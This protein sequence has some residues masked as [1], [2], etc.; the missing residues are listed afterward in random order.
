MGRLFKALR[1]AASLG[2]LAPGAL[3]HALTGST[4]DL[5]YQGM[6]RL[7]CLTGGASNDF[8]HG[9]LRRFRGC[10][11]LAPTDGVL[12]TFDTPGLA[13]VTEQ[14]REQGYYVFPKLLSDAVV[15]ELL[16]YALSAEGYYVPGT[17]RKDEAEA[18]RR[19][20][21]F[22]RNRPL[23]VRFD[24]PAATL[25]KEPA[26]QRLLTDRSILAVA[27]S[28]LGCDPILDL[29]T[30]WWHTAASPEPS[31]EA[32]QLFHFDMDRI[33]WLKF[34]VYLTDVDDRSG[35]HV[36]VPGSH[37]RSGIPWRMLQKGY[38]RLSDDEVQAYYGPD[39]LRRFTGPRGTV[40]AEDTRGLHKGAHVLEG[41][42]LVF[43]LEFVD[44]LFGGR[45]SGVAIPNPSADLL[46]LHEELP[47]LF[48]IFPPAVSGS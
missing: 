37:R 19:A 9:V 26:I 13:A 39:G 25:V 4:P 16:R 24:Y 20:K 32:A 3:W 40:I 46:K 15:D 11:D 33:K 41:D 22:D 44:S 5:A 8:A 48:R 35:P 10:R 7:F 47:S 38:A 29:V 12:G 18:A 31:A 45:H 43:Q 36:F 6:I 34:F 30:M 27:Q 17:E 21:T 42:R 14:L 2:A 23:G 28:Y 1:A